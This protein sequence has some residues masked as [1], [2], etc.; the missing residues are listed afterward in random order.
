[1]KRIGLIG[2]GRHGSRYA[3][4]IVRDLDR[5][6]LTGISRRSEE[7]IRQAAGWNTRY[8]RDWCELVADPGVDAVVAVAVPSLN[9]EIARLCASYGKPLLM[10]KPLARNGREAAEIVGLMADAGCPL[11]VGQTL[12]YNPVIGSLRRQLPALGTLHSL[13]VN[14][15][16]EPSTLAWHDDPE[17][18][19]AGVIIHTAVHIFDALRVITGLRIR[20]VMAT[21]RCVH[22]RRLEDLVTVLLEMENG[23]LGTLDVSKVGQARSGRFE[24]VCRE[25]QLHGDQIHGYTRHIRNSSMLSEERFPQVPTILR[26]LEDW[27]EFLETGQ[28][29][30]VSGEDGLYAVRV[31]DGCRQS[32]AEHRWVEI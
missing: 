13:A 5:F 10:E 20:R 3:N 6:I 30:P 12:R 21:G 11:T 8:F 23:V 27:A 16:I 18:A 15:R 32:A 28:N 2:S 19:G 26:L 29:N 4:H 31:C 9:L 14:Q 24:F 17:T 7:G 1:M 25:G 22:S